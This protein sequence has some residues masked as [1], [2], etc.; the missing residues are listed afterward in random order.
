MLVNNYSQVFC[1]SVLVFILTQNKYNNQLDYYKNG[2]SRYQN[3]YETE[4]AWFELN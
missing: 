3:V 2:Q 1:F 4:M